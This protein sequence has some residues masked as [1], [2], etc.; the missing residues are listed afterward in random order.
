MIAK[1]IGSGS[2]LRGMG[3]SCF[4]LGLVAMAHA[5]AQTIWDNQPA[6]K[7]TDA[8][9][10][11]NGRLGALPFGTYPQEKILINEETIWARGP[12]LEMPA[13]SASVLQNIQSLEASGDY[14]AADQALVDGLLGGARH[15]YS[16]QFFGDIEIQHQRAGEPDVKRELELGTGISRA[17]YTFPNGDELVQEV[18]A[19]APDQVLLVRLHSTAG[20]LDFAVGFSGGGRAEG[21]RLIRD[22]AGDWVIPPS[23][24]EREGEKGQGTRYRGVLAAYPAKSV[25]GTGA[26]LVVKGTQE[27]WLV[28]AVATDFDRQAIDRIA[29]PGWEKAAEQA[30]GQLEGKDLAERFELAISDHQ[31]LYQRLELDLGASSGELLALPTRERLQRFKRRKTD[32]PDL[33]ETYF[34]FGRYLLIASSRPGTFPANLQGIWNPHRKAPW[35][36]DFHL[37]I[38]LQMNYW[39]AET[40]HLAECHQPLF[41][42]MRYLLPTGREMARRMGMPGWCMGHATDIWGHAKLMGKQARHGGTFFGGQWLTFHLLE[43]Y[44]FHRDPAVLEEHWDLLSA[45]T[46]FVLAWLIPGRKEP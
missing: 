18:V 32:D 38:N 5:E 6:K 15:P 28:L 9:P 41:D 40:T 25:E 20:E 26:R 34:Q 14:A 22:G 8:Y 2:L 31:Q 29:P 44:R 21:N 23:M 35:S 33:I 19:S 16:Y 10:V 46:E 3:V 7:W 37:N 24:A 27:A 36:S 42:F 11:G 13:D 39:P 17:R 30:I 12:A 45:S 43:H 1:G 4:C